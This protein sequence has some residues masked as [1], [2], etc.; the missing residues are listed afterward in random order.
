MWKWQCNQ[1]SKGFYKAVEKLESSQHLDHA[2]IALQPP[3]GPLKTHSAN[4]PLLTE[5]MTA[6]QPPIDLAQLH[7][8]NEPVSSHHD[9]KHHD[10]ADYGQHNEP[11][12]H[13]HHDIIVADGENVTHVNDVLDDTVAGDVTPQSVDAEGDHGPKVDVVVDASTEKEGD[14]HSVE[15]K[16]DHLP[17]VDAVVEVVAEGI[18]NLASVQAKGDDVP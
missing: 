4:E 11:G 17:Q 8:V 18:G 1:K 12:V 7:S 10:D 14:L 3:R 5:V 13:I 16:E 9:G 2:T 15:A 6:P